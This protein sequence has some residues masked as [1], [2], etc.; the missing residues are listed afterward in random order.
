MSCLICGK[1][2]EIHHVWTRKAFPEFEHCEWN[3]MALCRAHHR[4]VHS[5]GIRRFADKFSAIDNWLRKNQWYFDPV[6]FRWQH[7]KDEKGKNP[8]DA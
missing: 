5:F 7:R 8:S 6:V 3:K 2:S 4:E 1:P